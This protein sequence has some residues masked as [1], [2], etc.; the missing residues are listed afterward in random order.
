[1]LTY[2]IKNYAIK[3][4]L[5]AKVNE[6]SSHVVATPHGG[7]IAIVITWFIGLIFLYLNN[8]VEENLFY[9]LLI[10]FGI[11]IVSLIDDIIELKASIRIVSH[12]VFAV[13]GMFALGGL[14]IIDFGLFS[15]SNEYFISSIIGTIAIVYFINVFNF[16]DG[17]N[18]L[19]GSEIIF[20]ALAGYILF[21]DNHFL[22][23]L[24]AVL[25]FLYWNFG[26]SA[27]IFMGDVSST[28][29]GYTVA[30]FTIY[31]TNIESSNLWVWLI[32]FSFFWFDAT[33]T[34]LR[35]TINGEKITQAHKKHGYQ[36]LQQSGWSHL[37]VTLFSI[38]INIILFIIVYSVANILVAFF[39]SLI[40][41]YMVTKFID[42][43][44]AFDKIDKKSEVL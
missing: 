43:R 6:R 20:L 32:L 26:N 17:L 38:M 44:K 41:L 37:R 35:R 4:A 7:G 34:I 31:Y 15:I 14:E 9:A 39:S 19:S 18:G 29:L 40:V 23:L 3:K 28:L 10:G 16:M 24:V 33:L 21:S 8:Q 2:F 13:L 1:M 42:N 5:L 12:C 25:G 30:I 11:S 22:V 27:K 36:R